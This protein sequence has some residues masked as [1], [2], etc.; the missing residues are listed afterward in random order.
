MNS[1]T[2]PAVLEDLIETLED[3]RK[4]FEQA[5]DRIEESGNDALVVDLRRLSRQREE[6]SVE[7]RTLASR[8][9]FEIDEE[10]SMAGALHRG[11][12]SLK[13]ALTGDDPKAVLAAA[14]TGEDHAVS[15]FQDALGKDLPEDVRAVVQRQ[16]EAV[17]RA[18]DE[19]KALRDTH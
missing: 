9:G 2:T 1:D 18:H 19:V 8:H 11:W 7:L 6:F 15:E 13:D 17:R 14:E 16:A 12:M 10:G 4:G 3:G 5:A